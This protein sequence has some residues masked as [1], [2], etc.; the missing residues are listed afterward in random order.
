MV[1]MSSAANPRSTYDE[2]LTLFIFT[3]AM[4]W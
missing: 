4:M 2:V 1:L 3:M